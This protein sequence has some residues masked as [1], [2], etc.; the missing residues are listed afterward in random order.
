MTVQVTDHHR[1]DRGTEMFLT[2]EALARSHRDE[3]VRR[4]VQTQRAVRLREA[5]LAEREARRAVS[6]ARDAH[7]RASLVT[8]SR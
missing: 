4:A 8:A 7:L 5:L 2:S 6:R 3:R 1:P